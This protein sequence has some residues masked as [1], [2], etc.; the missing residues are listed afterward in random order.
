[1]MFAYKVNK[2]V[3]HSVTME[4]LRPVVELPLAPLGLVS[5]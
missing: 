5:Q 2:N 4:M 3:G 1:M